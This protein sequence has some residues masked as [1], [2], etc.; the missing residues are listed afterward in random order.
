MLTMNWQKW[1]K[2]RKKPTCEMLFKPE[3]ARFI[4]SSEHWLERQETPA[5]VS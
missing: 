1:C 3:T 2:E 5:F 4:N